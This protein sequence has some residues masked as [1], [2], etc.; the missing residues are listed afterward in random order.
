MQRFL[1]S[2]TS[3]ILN[4]QPSACALVFPLGLFDPCHELPLL[5]LPFPPLAV[6]PPPA[7]FSFF[8]HS[9]PLSCFLSGVYGFS[10]LQPDGHTA[11]FPR[12]ALSS[13]QW[14]KPGCPVQIPWPGT[15]KSQP[16]PLTP[17]SQTASRGRPRETT[18]TLVLLPPWSLSS[19]HA[20][21]VFASEK[22]RV[23]HH[24]LGSLKQP[25]S[26]L[27]LI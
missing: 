24:S 8:P 26:D 3:R 27:D 4:A 6:P 21:L 10:T 22:S 18:W 17:V 12:L 7:P 25:L 23:I 14:Q 15:L 11:A 2:A 20:C 1:I 16:H 13:A 9:F 5:L 19:C